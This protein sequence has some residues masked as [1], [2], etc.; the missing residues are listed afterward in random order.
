MES[1]TTIE[2]NEV[3]RARRLRDGFSEDIVRDHI[4]EFFVQQGQPDTT[5]IGDK[6][7]LRALWVFR[8]IEDIMKVFRDT[9][10]KGYVE[11]YREG[12]LKVINVASRMSVTPDLAL[13]R[14][15]YVFRYYGQ[16]KALIPEECSCDIALV[17]VKRGKAKLDSYQKEDVKIAE[18]EG[19]PYYLIR[20]DDSG[21]LDG[22]FLLDRQKLT[23][24]AFPI[25]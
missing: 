5:R 9:K 7:L 23:T 16:G 11:K 8:P 25:S 19:I 22:R 18:A 15:T 17:E 3:L 6:E 1:I 4:R 13:L 21:F 20:V 14:A 2:V 12:L 24:C 10:V